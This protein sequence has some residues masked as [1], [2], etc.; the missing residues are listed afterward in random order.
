[1]KASIEV[2]VFFLIMGCSVLAETSSSDLEAEVV[3]H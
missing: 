2:V 1:M 3:N